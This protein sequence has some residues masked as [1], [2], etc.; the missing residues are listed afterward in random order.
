MLFIDNIHNM[1][2]SREQQY[3]FHRFLSGENLFIT[4][5]GGTGKTF[6]IREMVKSLRERGIQYQVC[7]MTGCA[8]V[9]L[10]SGA[11]TLHS[12]TG[13]GLGNGLKESIA[14]KIAHNRKTLSGIKKTKVLIVDEVSM[15][16]KRIFEAVNL[17]MKLVKKL[18]AEFGGI[19]VIFTGDFFQLPPVGDKD[20]PDT[21][22]FC[23]E[24]D[25]W[26]SVFNP[27]CQIQL[28]KIL[29]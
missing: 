14:H 12:W 27:R 25:D 26:N 13:M 15:M 17:A 4:G 9:L 19:Q 5:P 6:L 7:A 10:G 20:E 29:L 16:S 8:A 3:A 2:F 1:S 18:Q 24:S 28:V 21:Q 23:F 11:K 22:R